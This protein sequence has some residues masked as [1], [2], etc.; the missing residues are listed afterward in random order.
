MA[1]QQ[2]QNNFNELIYI[3]KYQGIIRNLLINYKFNEK[4]YLVKTFVNFLLNDKNVFEK[5]QSF[6]IIVPVPISKK[7]NKQRGYNQSLLIAKEI[8]KITNQ[9][10][11]TNCLYKTK[12]ITEQ[13][14]LNKEKRIENIKGVYELKNPQILINKKVLLIDDIYTTG[15]TVNECCKMLQK[16]KTKEICVLVIAKD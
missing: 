10:I 5:L 1:N 8:S 9:K 13:S 3:F 14:K 6:D 4:P 11:V 12:N 16:V 7:R 2:E 15:S